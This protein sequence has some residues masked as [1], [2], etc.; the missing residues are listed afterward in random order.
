MVLR[1]A[2]AVSTLTYHT[3]HFGNNTAGRSGSHLLREVTRI[4]NVVHGRP[5]LTV[6]QQ[7]VMFRILKKKGGGNQDITS[8]GLLPVCLFG[9]LHCRWLNKSS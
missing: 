3:L 9:A 7:L 2:G 1:E 5:M 4:Q 6:V 8:E